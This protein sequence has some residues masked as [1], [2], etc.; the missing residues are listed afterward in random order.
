M[1]WDG[2]YKYLT[3]SELGTSLQVGLSASKTKLRE[4]NTSIEAL[5]ID[6]N[7]LHA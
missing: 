3:F 6:K 4:L 5:I 7:K 2:E 1:W